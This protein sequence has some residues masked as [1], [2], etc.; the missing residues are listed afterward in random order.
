[1][2][3]ATRCDATKLRSVIYDETNDGSAIYDDTNEGDNIYKA[4]YVQGIVYDVPSDDDEEPDEGH[5]GMKDDDDM[6]MC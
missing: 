6:G 1:M 4:E 2:F 5:D 3:G